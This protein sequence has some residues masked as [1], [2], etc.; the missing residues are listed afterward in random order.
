MREDIHYKHSKAYNKANIQQYNNNR[1]NAYMTDNKI[2]MRSS[3]LIRPQA[4]GIRI[5]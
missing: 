3:K 5:A 2:G 4:S 1:T